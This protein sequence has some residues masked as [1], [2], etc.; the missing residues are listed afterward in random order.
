MAEKLGKIEKPEV[1][2]FT[3]SRKIVVAPLLF[4][5]KDAPEDFLEIFNRCWKQIEEQIQNLE[6]KL[7]KV[8]RIYHEMIFNEGEEGLKILEQLNPESFDLV[9]NRCEAGAKLQ[10]TEDAELALENMDWERCLMVAMGPKVRSKIIQF[11]R[12]S[13]SARY[14]H[15]GKQIEETLEEGEIGLF[16]AR[17]GHPTQFPE[18]AEVFNVAPPALDELN[19]WLRDYSQKIA[20]QMPETEPSE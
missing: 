11:H 12:E 6:R 17:E 4:S 9:K 10:S 20:S 8:S 2:S 13:S 19:R 16:F 18:D 3:A 14:Q 15:I 5:G 7:G 1:E